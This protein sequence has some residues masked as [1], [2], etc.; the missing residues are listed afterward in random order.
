MNYL[1]DLISNEKTQK[2]DNLSKYFIL[3]YKSKI[4]NNRYNFKLST[5]DLCWLSLINNQTDILN[6]IFQNNTSNITWDTIS[7]YNIP[8]WIKNDLK[9]KELIILSS[10]YPF[11]SPYF[12]CHFH[13]HFHC[14]FHFH[15]LT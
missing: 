5:S 12:H 9:L 1:Y 2:Y 11:L 8:L 14:H 3:K 15:F 13:F 4:N 6:F 7:K 10:F